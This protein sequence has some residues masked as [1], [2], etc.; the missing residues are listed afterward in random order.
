MPPQEIVK[1]F[2]T[3]RVR[4][5]WD[6]EKETWYFSIVDVVAVLTESKSPLAY[7]RKLKQRLKEEGN[8]TVT[9]CHGLKLQA[10]DGKM[11]LTDV[12][13]ADQMF[14]VIHASPRTLHR[15]V[16][17]PFSPLA[18]ASRRPRLAGRSPCRPF[19][20]PLCT[21]F[22]PSVPVHSFHVDPVLHP[23]QPNNPLL[24]HHDIRQPISSRRPRRPRL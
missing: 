3:H 20:L 8:Q 23:P 24:F 11:R 22:R 15:P 6:D 10:A 2:G 5:I 9:N 12:V 17:H 16:P 18:A 4:T 14:R 13:T 7:W 21:C 19:P 1:A